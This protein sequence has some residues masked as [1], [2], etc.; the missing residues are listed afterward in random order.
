MYL[1]NSALEHWK[2]KSGLGFLLFTDAVQQ[3]QD[4]QTLE[5]ENMKPDI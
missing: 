2:S 5:T 4:A 1:L 3:R